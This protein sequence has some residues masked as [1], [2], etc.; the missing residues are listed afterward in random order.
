MGWEY[1]IDL[2]NIYGASS[3]YWTLPFKSI[4][5]C[6]VGDSAWWEDIGVPL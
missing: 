5:T 1:S 6:I 2:P 4:L 3:L